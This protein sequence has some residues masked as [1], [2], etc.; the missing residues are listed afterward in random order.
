MLNYDNDDSTENLRQYKSRFSLIVEQIL[1]FSSSTYLV[2]KVD[3]F[4]PNFKR[5]AYPCLTL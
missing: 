3:S 1:A 5:I 4:P 2:K